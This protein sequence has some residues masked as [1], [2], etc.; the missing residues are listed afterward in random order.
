MKRTRPLLHA[1][2]FLLTL[3]LALAAFAQSPSI[4][5]PPD[6]PKRPV[7]DEYQGVKVIDDYRWLENWDDPAV[8]Q[9]S[10]AQNA[11][12]REYLD[13]LPAR[14]AIKDRL[15]QL[16]AASSAAYY[17]LQFR[18]GMLF[19]MKYQPPQQQPM[20]VVLRSA[21][22]P[23]SARVIFDPNAASAKGAL[24]V[25]FYVPSFGSKYVAA[26]LSENGSEDAS[27]HIF[28]VDTGKE[29][30]DVVPRVNFATAGGS[31][32][33]KADNSGFYYTRY[34]QGNERPPADA[35]FY[36][37]VYFHKL[38]TDPKEDAYV[39][40]KDFPRIA[41]IHLRTSD[42]GRWLLVSVGNGDGGQFAH[43]LMDLEGHWTQLTHFE[44]GIVAVKFGVDPGLYLL[45]R[46]DAPRGQILRLP[47]D[48]LDLAQARVIVPQSP[49]GAPGASGDENDRAS[50]ENFVPA[51]N[52][53]Y[54]IDIIGGP[55]RMRVFERKASDRGPGASAP[56][57]EQTGEVPLPPV[58][59]I[60]QVVS[61]GAGD[62]LFYTSTYITPA[63]WYHF[64]A[65]TGKATRTALYETSPVSFDDAEVVREFA[66]SKDGTRVPM[67]IIRRKGTTL[68]GSNPALLYGYGGYGISEMP[69]FLGSF[70]RSWL[71]QGGVYVD[72]NLR[73]G[74]EYGEEWH[75]AGNLTHKQNVFDD[76]IASAQYLIDHKYTAPAH[77]AILGGSNGGLLMGAAFTQRPD[78]FRAVVSEVGI[79]DMLRVELDPNGAFNVTEFGTVKDP[80]QFKALY[81]YSPYHH[82][83]NGTAYPAV[84]MPTGEND[85]RV[86]PM[87][88]RKMI[89]RLQAATSSNRPILLRTSSAAGHGSIG[90]ALDEQIEQQADMVSFLFD[91]L[92]IQYAAA[93]K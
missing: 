91:Q 29:L 72:A 28:D 79:Y 20:L 25:D 66:T 2:H 22:D 70:A 85:H 92:G 15:H 27:A 14:A 24:A 48:H 32:A 51:W 34:P 60:G 40:G 56:G 74:A 17:G 65:A 47:L 90:A 21:D 54:V 84:Y 7:T 93:Q 31:I 82:V 6:T 88:S 26:A 63:A 86:N 12:T 64:D 58:S 71:D 3:L 11:R 89:A 37:Q 78:L 45:S 69:F 50:I 35:N 4:P 62:V 23:A 83:K 30:S 42:D 44:D 33:W 36:Q 80:D 5:K 38:G 41:E 19:A 39:I 75:M 13:H 57:L 52:H 73:G 16:V 59:A 67:N 81:A 68:D 55:S 53:L 1:T 87:Q 77:L 9:W 18:A 46:K 43:Y 76:F 10:A 8:K 49:G 61:I